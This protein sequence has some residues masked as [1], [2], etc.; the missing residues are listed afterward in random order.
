MLL[1]W[2]PGIRRA[3]SGEPSPDR[4]PCYV[5]EGDDVGKD[6]LGEFE[7]MVLLAAMRLGE[8]QAYALAIVDDIA[9][10]TDRSVRR[11][12]VYMTVQR[13]EKKGLITTWLGEP[14]SERGGKARRH[15]RLEEQGLRAVHESRTALERMAKRPAATT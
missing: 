11:S 12:A 4:V 1:L 3:L 6:T 5:G 10:R 14:R 2:W 7:L 15:I 13:L 9:Q 8:E